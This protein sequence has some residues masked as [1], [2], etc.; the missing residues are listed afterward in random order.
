MTDEG[1]NTVAFI[2]GLTL[3][4]KVSFVLSLVLVVRNSLD[5]SSGQ[6]GLRKTAHKVV[7]F[8][9]TSSTAREKPKEVQHP[10]NLVVSPSI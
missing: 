1:T 6:E 8:F 9:Q 7:A 2:R 4:F 3:R 5:G 10:I